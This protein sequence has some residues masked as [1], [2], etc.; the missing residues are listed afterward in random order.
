MNSLEKIYPNQFF[1]KRQAHLSWRAPI[2]CQSLVHLFHPRS[3]ID[4]GCA[5]GDLVDGFIKLG[6]DAFG[7]E[8]ATTA[9]PHLMVPIERVIVH[10]LR[11]PLETDQMFDLVVCFEVAEHIEP[12][13]ADVFADNITSICNDWLIISA[14]PPGQGGTYHVNCQN[15]QFWISKMGERGFAYDDLKGSEFRGMLY[16]WRDKTGIR[17]YYG[18]VMVFQLIKEEWNV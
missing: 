15:H 3:A 18:N 8:G 4:I 17:A 12:E 6:V 1:K 10:D 11:K 9:L 2:V 16:P 7:L 14:A 13:Y 5:V